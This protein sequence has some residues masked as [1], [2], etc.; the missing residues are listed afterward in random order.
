MGLC[1]DHIEFLGF[2]VDVGGSGE[3]WPDLA[4]PRTESTELRQDPQIPR[5]P[6]QSSPPRFSFDL[7]TFLG[8][9]G[10]RE[11]T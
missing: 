3:I 4:R 6:I 1:R 8:L 10:D 5:S 9:V 2:F 11:A 7:T